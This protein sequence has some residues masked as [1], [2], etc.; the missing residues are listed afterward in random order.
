MDDGLPGLR[1]AL[2]AKRTAQ[3]AAAKARHREGGVTP[4]DIAKLAQTAFV[5]SVGGPLQD[6][7]LGLRTSHPAKLRARLDAWRW[8]ERDRNAYGDMEDKDAIEAFVDGSFTVCTVDNMV[9]QALPRYLPPCAQTCG[10]AA[11][12]PRSRL[13]RHPPTSNRS[14]WGR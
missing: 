9:Y 13:G 8:S 4:V 1:A 3:R 5:P 2:K 14:G 7:A 12:V 11:G 10:A 6:A